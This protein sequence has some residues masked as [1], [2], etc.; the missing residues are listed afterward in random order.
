[1]AV[2]SNDSNTFVREFAIFN[3]TLNIHQ[4]FVG[5]VGCVVWDA[6]I[7]LAKYLEKTRHDDLKSKKILELGAGTGIVGLCCCLA[8]C[9]KSLLYSYGLLRRNS[10]AFSFR[11]EGTCMFMLMY[12]L[13]FL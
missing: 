9:V 13:Y 12:E 4:A 2:L 10:K 11:Y 7:V 5:D 6:A 8:G 1:M 3:T